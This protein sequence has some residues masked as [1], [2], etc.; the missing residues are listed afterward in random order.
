M[1]YF[2]QFIS[3]AVAFLDKD[4]GSKMRLFLIWMPK[5]RR[6]FGA[7][8]GGQCPAVFL[9]LTLDFHISSALPS[10]QQHRIP[11]A[12]RWG[13]FHLGPG[14]SLC[15]SNLCKALPL[16][17]VVLTKRSIHGRSSLFP[18]EWHQTISFPYLCLIILGLPPA[19]WSLQTRHLLC[20]LSTFYPFSTQR[21]ATPVQRL[22]IH[23]KLLLFCITSVKNYKLLCELAWTRENISCSALGNHPTSSALEA[24]NPWHPQQPWNFLWSRADKNV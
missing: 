15:C 17:W 20:H 8:L 18:F 4:H 16:E 24:E 2:I 21:P 22:C 6:I 13:A 19:L 9:L 3:K 23:G 12:E 10:A 7:G 14:L 5:K 1:C 11:P